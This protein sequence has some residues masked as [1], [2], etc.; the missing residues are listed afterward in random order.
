MCS[1][2][3]TADS[4]SNDWYHANWNIED[5]VNKA[6]NRCKCI[7][8]NGYEANCKKDW[9]NTATKVL[10]PWCYVEDDCQYQD[11]TS[12]KDHTTKW[13]RCPS[14]DSTVA[15]GDPEIQLYAAE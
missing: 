5:N 12:K 2:G 1:A 10:T 6:P 9:W 8:H 4:H 14:S 7:K 3:M 13:R 15:L 11:G